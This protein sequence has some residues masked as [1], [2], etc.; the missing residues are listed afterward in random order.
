MYGF[1]NPLKCIY[2]I[3]VIIKFV[4]AVQNWCVRCG[5]CGVIGFHSSFGI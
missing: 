1:L 3:S 4:A 5:G 2:K